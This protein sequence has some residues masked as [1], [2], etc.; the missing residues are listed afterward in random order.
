MKR[1][2]L[3][4]KLSLKYLKQYKKKQIFNDIIRDTSIIWDV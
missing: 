2:F 1:S 4:Q 3:K